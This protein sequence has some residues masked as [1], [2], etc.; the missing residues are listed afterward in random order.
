MAWDEHSLR[1]PLDEFGGGM[2]TQELAT[3]LEPNQSPDLQNVQPIG[4]HAYGPRFGRTLIGN[5][6]NTPGTARSLFTFAT[7]FATLESQPL[8]LAFTGSGLNDL[9]PSG[10]SNLGVSTSWVVRIVSAGMVDAISVTE[11]PAGG[12]PRTIATIPIPDA[13]FQPFLDG[14]S[15]SM[16]QTGHTVGAQWT[17]NTEATHFGFE[18]LVKTWGTT[19]EY[20]LPATSIW[21]TVPGAPVYTNNQ[22]F[23]WE[24]DD[25]YMYGGNGVDN[26]FRWDGGDLQ[27]IG[28]TADD[29]ADTIIPDSGPI[30]ALNTRVFFKTAGTLP[31]GLSANTAY[32]IINPTGSNFQVSTVIGGSAVD[33][34][35]TGTGTF[36][37]GSLLQEYPDNPKGNIFKFFDGRLWVTGD[38]TKSIRLY[39]SD[40]FDSSAPDY[41]KYV[42][43]SNFI[44]IPV[45]GDPI[46]SLKV[47]TLA[48]GDSFGLFVYKKSKRIFVLTLNDSG[49]AYQYD[50]VTRNTGAIN[51]R[52]V[53]YVDNEMFYINPGNNISKL[54]RVDEMFNEIR[55]SPMSAIIDRSLFKSNWDDSCGYFFKK[56][57]FVVYSFKQ[58][59][60][61]SNDTQLVYFQDFDSWWL[62][63]GIDAT[64]FDEYQGNL[65]FSDSH[66]PNVYLYDEN[67]FSDDG[68]LDESGNILSGVISSYRRTEDMEN[69]I[70]I[71]KNKV[72]L[73]D[74]Y[75]Q[76]RFAILKGYITKA[77]KMTFQVVYDGNKNN[78]REVTITGDSMVVTG[79]ASGDA[80]IV[81]GE[82]IFAEDLFGGGFDI[83]P[84]TFEL[85]EFFL[86]LSLDGYTYQKISLN[87]TTED[88]NPY[89]IGFMNL[90]LTLLDEEK[91]SELNKP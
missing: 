40:P 73:R 85:V 58:F 19:I 34:M 42:T 33:I 48:N 61:N 77:G 32:Y 31:S 24:S 14:I 10:N 8:N 41:E 76:A 62:W 89:L 54:G 20:L 74:R 17:F 75:K 68:G 82:T 70:L 72:M 1:N 21:T 64:Q 27:P 6:N 4:K 39:Y 59:G 46:T 9:V 3:Y 79:N 23:G 56:R 51:D 29:G 66:T 69:Y 7:P 15:L 91:A 16:A 28:F 52:S 2:N 86:M 45:G 44:D 53:V 80:N 87:T 60:S 88:K 55:T 67:K 71:Q 65:V 18:K 26:F 37:F 11:T 49:D 63:K 5:I 84:N 81:F 47:G 25:Q 57:R 43:F 12:S 22:K 36:V 90:W 35:D 38:M 50:E 83:A 13:P 78:T 30:P